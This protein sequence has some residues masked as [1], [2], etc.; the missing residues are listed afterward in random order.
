MNNRVVVCEKTE[1][2]NHG[3]FDCLYSRLDK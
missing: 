3:L 2:M 1:H